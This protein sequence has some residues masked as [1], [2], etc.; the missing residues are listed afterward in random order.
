LRSLPLEMDFRH[1]A[2][3]SKNCVANFSKLKKTSLVVPEVLWSQERILVM[4]FIEGGRVD[5][6]EYLRKHGI[7]RS[8]CA[9]VDGSPVDHESRGTETL[10][11][12]RCIDRRCLV[13]DFEDILTDALYRWLLPR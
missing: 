7:D 9:L 2:A 12:I 13:R 5:D 1:E 10:I 11:V 6:L 8:E 4:E 3:N